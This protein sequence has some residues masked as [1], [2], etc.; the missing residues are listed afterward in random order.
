MLSKML[1]KKKENNKESEN[2]PGLCSKTEAKKE[3]SDLTS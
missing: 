3:P 1:S 2:S